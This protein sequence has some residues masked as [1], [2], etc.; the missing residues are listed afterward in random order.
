MP[1]R[2]GRGAHTGKTQAD[3]MLLDTC[4]TGDGGGTGFVYLK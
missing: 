3:G 4:T 2:T 1:L